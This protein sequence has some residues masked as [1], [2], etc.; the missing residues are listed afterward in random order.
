MKPLIKTLFFLLVLNGCSSTPE[1]RK[2]LLPDSSGQLAEVIVIT[3]SRS[4]DSLYKEQITN[5]FAQ[6]MEGHP[7][8][9]EPTFKILF[10]DES[11]FKGY[12]KMH[13]NIFILL[14]TENAEY[15]KKILGD[16]AIDNM[17]S[18]KKSKPETFGLLQ[19]DIYAQNQKIFYILADNKAEMI[20]RLEEKKE[21]I[22]QLALK[23]ENICGKRKMLGTTSVKK[24][25]FYQKCISEKG[26]GVRK[27]KTYRVAVDNDEFV[28]LRKSSTTNELEQGLLL[29]EAPYTS[30]DNLTTENLIKIRNVFAKKY[31]P[32]EYKNSYMKYSEVIKPHRKDQ[33]FKGKYGVEIRGWWDVQGDFMGGPSYIRAVVDE[34]RGRIVFAEGFLFFPNE[35]KVKQMRELEI[36]VNTLSIK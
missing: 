16:K 17:V 26:F 33:N 19:E 24:D 25:A 18:I 23:H 14:N 1:E 20:E 22:V 11:F 36:L 30:E 34:A 2:A 7:P 10:T 8:P 9:G 31:I 15:L 5:V 28:W 35:A 27:P 13:Q 12:F 3:D 21:Y 4:T 32:G 29:F 6:N